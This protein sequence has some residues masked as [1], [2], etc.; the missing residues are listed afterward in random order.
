MAAPSMSIRRWRAA[1]GVLLVGLASAAAAQPA[2]PAPAASR[3]GG[4]G[5]AGHATAGCTGTALAC[6]SAAMP[7]ID[8]RGTLWLVWVAG[9]S[10]SSARS[11]DGGRSFTLPVEIGR[12]GSTLDLGS[13]AKPQIV[14]DAKGRAVVAYGVFKDKQWNAQ[15]MVSTSSDGGATFSEPRSLSAD[16]A[17]QRFPALAIDA[18]GAVV[19]SWLDKRTAAAARRKGQTQSGAALAFARSLDGG[20][21]FD[22]ERIAQDR[23]C[24]CCRIALTI[25]PQGRPVALFRNIFEGRERDHAVLTFSRSGEPGAAYRVAE[26]H[27]AID[28]CPHHGPSVAV[29]AD[30]SLLAAWFTQGQARQGLFLARSTDGG[31]QFSAPLPVGDPQQQPGRPALLARGDT[32]WLAWKE[33]DGQRILVKLRKSQDAGRSWS[34]DRTLAETRNT[35]DHPVLLSDPQHLYLS[36]MTRDEGYRLLPLDDL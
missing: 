29:A 10:V 21:T 31:K 13:D 33:F 36:W 35:A 16:A 20:A 1:L 18:D 15:V 19:A 3:V 8:A 30:G 17:S 14:V 4:M 25:D 32:V 26:D 7:F 9:G 6:A 11:T 5:H 22:T 28:A 2:A 24:E 12:H 23:T 34:P 27:W